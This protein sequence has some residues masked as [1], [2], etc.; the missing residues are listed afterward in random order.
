MSFE[1]LAFYDDFSSY[2]YHTVISTQNRY[3][4]NTNQFLSIPVEIVYQYSGH[5][6]KFSK[7][8]IES[9]KT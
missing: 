5:L 2:D 3:H 6:F 7:K 4:H 1:I 8:I 9:V